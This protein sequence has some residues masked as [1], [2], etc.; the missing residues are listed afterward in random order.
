M[1]NKLDKKY[2]GDDRFKR[3]D[4][5]FCG[6]P[7][8]FASTIW[9]YTNRFHAPIDVDCAFFNKRHPSEF[10]L[11]ESP[12]YILLGLDKEFYHFR[13]Q[14]KSDGLTWLFFDVFMEGIGSEADKYWNNFLEYLRKHD[15]LVEFEKSTNGDKNNDTNEPWMKITDKLWYREAVKLLHEGCSTKEIAGR[16]KISEGRVNNLFSDLRDEHGKDIIPLRK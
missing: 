13:A 7:K 2:K 1:L 9:D 12:I 8:D 5:L 3:Y 16:L 4:Y 11:E 6:R 10:H 15:F 14:Y